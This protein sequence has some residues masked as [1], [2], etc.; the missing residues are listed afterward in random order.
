MKKLIIGALVAAIIL[1]IWQFLSW[2]GLSLHAAEA[3]HTMDQQKILPVLAEH[4]QEGQYMLVTVPEGTGKD[5]MMDPEIMEA[6][7]DKP[8]AMINYH[9]SFEMNMGVN[10]FRGFVMDLLAA[11]LLC[12]V[13]MK[14]GSLDFKTTLLASIAIGFIGYFTIPY[15]NH[16]WY[17]TDTIG[18]LIDAIVGW[19]LVG[20]WLGWF[21]TRG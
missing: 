16:I 14:I 8:W 6:M 18:Y 19:G 15:L 7:T 1:F 5:Q 17:E 11:L 21:L 2:Q 10:L 20:A 9:P 4:L 3:Q 13:L 12:W